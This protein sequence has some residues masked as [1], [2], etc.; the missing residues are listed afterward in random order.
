MYLT[1]KIWAAR[2]AGSS[3]WHGHIS[4]EEQLTRCKQVPKQGFTEVR[5]KQPILVY[6]C[7]M[8]VAEAQGCHTAGEQLSWVYRRI[9]SLGKRQGSRPWYWLPVDPKESR[10]HRDLCPS[11]GAAAHPFPLALPFGGHVGG[12]TQ[13]DTSSSLKGKGEECGL[14]PGKGG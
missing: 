3:R 2:P 1:V 5:G 13:G 9:S 6:G 12:G 4:L 10:S 7:E 11:A 8:G 14:Y